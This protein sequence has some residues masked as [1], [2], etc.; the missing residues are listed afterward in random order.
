MKCDFIKT[1]TIE[2]RFYHNKVL[3]VSVKINYP[4]LSSN[5]SGNSTLFN[6]HYRQKANRNYRYASTKLYQTAVKQYRG[7]VSQ[8]F[9][10]HSFELI[11][12]FEPTYCNKPLISLFYDIYEFTGGAHGNT[13]RRGNTWDMRRGTLLELDSLFAR[14]Y[15]YKPVILK[16]IESEAKRR[17]ITGRAHYFDNLEENLNKYFDPKNFYLTEEG[18]AIFYP[19]YTIAPY[20]DGIQVF[21]IP[22]RMFG[23]NIKYNLN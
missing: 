23:D 6:M 3:M 17:Q 22:Y 10:F 9:P 13:V 12:T 19:L 5:Y 18:L 4:V 11:E 7:S 8:G 21:V 20:S 16:H 2:D 1:R 15:D 14:N